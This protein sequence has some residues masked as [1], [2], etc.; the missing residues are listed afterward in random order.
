MSDPAVPDRPSDPLTSPAPALDR[1]G[2][3]Q[4]TV[5][6]V[7]ILTC[8]IILTTFLGDL[9]V[10]IGYSIWPSYLL[11]IWLSR[12]WR[13]KATIIG[14]AISC[15]I[16]LILDLLL[17]PAGPYG[18]AGGVNKLFGIGMIVIAT[19][20]V[21]Q[22]EETFTRIHKEV[23]RRREAEEQL[24]EHAR[25]LDLRRADAMRAAQQAEEA[26]QLL[27]RQIEEHRQTEQR[28]RQSREHYR[29]VVE[30][31]YDAY[32]AINAE[33]RII[34]WNRQ[35]EQTFG[36]SRGEALNYR[37]SELIIPPQHQE[38]H[39]RGLA[40]FL[41]SGEG[42]VL[43]QRL[44]LSARHRDGREFPVQVT[45]WPVRDEEQWTFHAF[46]HEIERWR[47]AEQER[48]R[49]FE[50]SP[51]MLC[52]A[53]FD[54]YFKQVNPAFQRIL[55]HEPA[56]LLGEPFLNFV[57]PDD[58][59]AT[60]GEMDHLA[61]GG[62]TIAF[63][64]RYRCR[65]GSY[66]WVEWAA[67]A[68]PGDGLIYAG[69]RDVTARIQDEARLRHLNEQLA[70]SNADLE[71]FA[72]ATS[73][74]LREPL[75]TIQSF[76]D[77]IRSRYA[78]LLDEQGH[79]WIEYVTGAATRMRHLIEGLQTYSKLDAQRNPPEWTE[80]HQTLASVVESLDRAIRETQARVT[81]GESMPRLLVDEVQLGQLFQNLIGNAL[82]F[83]D[84]DRVP[85][86]Q[87]SAVPTGNGWQ[88][89]V[90][91]NGIGIEPTFFD[92]I[93]VMFRRLHGPDQY[94]G[95]GV[96]LAVCKRI[97]ER[98]GGRIWV[99]ST[100]G[101]GTT[102]LFTLPTC[103]GSTDASENRRPTSEDSASRGPG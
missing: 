69:A 21:L 81:I 87:V 37:L 59:E 18:R 82:K 24:R 67:H 49:F 5:P 22:I 93:F 70:R 96:G 74:D 33:G 73:H 58:H 38:S 30:T 61:A 4:A 66:R 91:D 17:S 92:K 46:L 75:R 36:W 8:S 6:I 80:I 85:E 60:L 103:G 43:N 28:L 12:S 65:D 79:R 50:V 72:H 41:T 9:F 83:R 14:V 100:P 101:H 88:F 40:H 7:G 55:G 44:E 35:A 68:F 76:L 51:E 32:V 31:A 15:V 48:R 77:L 99:E 11:A 39:E 10:P 71:L 62:E 16:L 54:G 56:D 23:I 2:E 63:R 86:I 29:A 57:H 45:I 98:H 90:A 27:Q 26:N 94:P 42:P 97:V 64:N 84:P 102:F 3:Q 53:G 25:E 19:L 34:A 89:S 52:V 47:W 20:W 1:S 13:G 95:S 78:T